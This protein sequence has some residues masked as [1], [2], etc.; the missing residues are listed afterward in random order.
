MFVAGIIVVA[1]SARTVAPHATPSSATPTATAQAPTR[2]G[3]TSEATTRTAA[4]WPAYTLLPLF[5]NVKSI[6]AV[7]DEQWLQHAKHTC[8]NA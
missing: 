6:F 2:A 8:T 1:R 3:I 4:D 5:F 7:H